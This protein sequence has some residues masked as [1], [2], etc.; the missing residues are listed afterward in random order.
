[1]GRDDRLPRWDDRQVI[2]L[3][4]EVLDGEEARS[5]GLATPAAQDSDRAEPS[6]A[7]VVAAG[8]A[9]YCWLDVIVTVRNVTRHHGP[10]AGASPRPGPTASLAAPPPDRRTIDGR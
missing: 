1:M 3:A 7:D 8:R 2:G 5:G 6:L 9:A 10:V 4:A